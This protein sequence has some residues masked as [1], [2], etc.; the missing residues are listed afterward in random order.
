MATAARPE[1]VAITSLPPGARCRLRIYAHDPSTNIRHP[2]H[3]GLVNDL[4]V[5]GAT[6]QIRRITLTDAGNAP[7]ED[8]LQMWDGID[9]RASSAGNA[10]LHK[11][12]GQTVDTTHNPG[13]VV[14]A[15]R[16]CEAR[17]RGSF[18]PLRAAKP[19]A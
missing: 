6:R 8:Q 15:V 19:A 18:A 4:A 14:H 17:L 5:V 16:T 7:G 3:A 12:P 11:T 10:L 1:T 9:V 2:H 13:V